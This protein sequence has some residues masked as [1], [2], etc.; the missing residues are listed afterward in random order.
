VDRTDRELPVSTMPGLVPFSPFGAYG[1]T[2]GS[3]LHSLLAGTE[4]GATFW[5]PPGTL[6]SSLNLLSADPSP[7]R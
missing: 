3:S 7:L 2:V 5:I 1:R 4:V 6:M